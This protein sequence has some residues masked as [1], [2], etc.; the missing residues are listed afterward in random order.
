MQLSKT[1]PPK[2]GESSEKS[3]GETRVK[4]CHV[5]GCHG[6]FGP[7]FVFGWYIRYKSLLMGLCQAFSPTLRKVCHRW[8]SGRP[9]DGHA[10][11]GNAWKST[12]IRD[13]RT[14]RP[15]QSMEHA[16]LPKGPFRSKNT[17]TIVK[18]VNY[19]AVVFLLRPPP[20]LLRCG[21]FFFRGKRL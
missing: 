10:S 13:R 11:S 19:Y 20:Y 14:E 1:S 9:R 15:G 3:S 18:R 17:T 8:T 6:F 16:G 12:S 5:C 7:E 21:P 4:S 2:S